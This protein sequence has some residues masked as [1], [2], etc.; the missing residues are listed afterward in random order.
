M[1]RHTF[2]CESDTCPCYLRALTDVA[3]AN[4]KFVEARYGDGTKQTEREQQDN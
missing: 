4:T 1:A 2:A 3:E